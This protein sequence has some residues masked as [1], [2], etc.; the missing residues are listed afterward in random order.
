MS[1][2]SEYSRLCRLINASLR[3]Y[4]ESEPIQLTKEKEKHLLIVLSQVSREIQRCGDELE[5]DS[6]KQPLVLNPV[7]GGHCF[8]APELYSECHNCFLEIL[9]ILVGLLNMKS[10]YIQHLVGNILVGISNFVSK[11][12]RNF[13]DFLHLLCVCIEVVISNILSSSSASLS[14]PNNDGLGLISVLQP[15]LVN[16]NWHVVTCLSRVLHN[17]LKYLKQNCSS[18]LAEIYLHSVSYGLSNVPW[19]LLDKIHSGQAYDMQIS[20]NG[21]AS[22]LRNICSPEAWFLFLGSLLQLFCSLVEQSGLVEEIHCS[23]DE[24]LLLDKITCLIPKILNWCFSVKWD[25]GN[26]CIQQYLRHKMLMLMTRLTLQVHWECSTLVLWL[27]LLRR[28]FQDLL[29]QPISAYDSGFDDSLEGSPFL[30]SIADGVHKIHTRHLQRQ[31][32]FLF[33]KCSFSLVGFGKETD[34]RCVC[35]SSNSCLTHELKSGQECS[36]KRK[37]LSEISE[38]LQDHLPLE[39]FVDYGIYS[40]KCSIFASSFMQLY[41]DEDDILFE[42]LLQ[43]LALPFPLE[44]VDWNDRCNAIHEAK[45]DI[46]YHVLNIFN[47]IHLFHL[48]LAKLH[49]DHSVLLD[50]LISKDIGVN[51]VQYLLRCLRLVFRSWNLFVDFSMCQNEIIQLSCKKRKVLLDGSDSHYKADISVS[52]MKKGETLGTLE[53][54]HKRHHNHGNKRFCTSQQPFENAK[55]CLLSLKRCVESLHHKNLFPYNPS[56][57]L[58]SFTRFQELCHQQE[59]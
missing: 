9:S 58:R 29:V 22:L 50:Y 41:V 48:F 54:E 23:L 14:D 12:G 31:A 1:C 47:P 59:K 20:S 43:L 6:G 26:A 37:G 17:I 11:S 32:I 19:D 25:S 10:Q 33:L 27:Q 21:N 4:T 36:G 56:A 8:P 34:I 49:Y 24:H 53:K 28:H 7:I 13:G 39:M 35:A 16:A 52:P 38:W 15:R 55:D 46:I 3:S 57:L 5:C 44:Q 40:E 42:V 18:E 2:S 51:C 45:G 30:A